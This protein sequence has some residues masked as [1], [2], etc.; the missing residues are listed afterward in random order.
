MNERVKELREQAWTMVSD[1][2]QAHGELYETR[3]RWDRYDQKFA[4]LIV[5]ECIEVCGSVAA[6]KE[7]YNDAA[8]ADTA[9]LCGDQ[10]KE[11]FGI[12]S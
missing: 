7:G 10:I 6:V 5:R 8:V 11:H 4:E 1:E 12:E 9:Y 2:Q 3:D